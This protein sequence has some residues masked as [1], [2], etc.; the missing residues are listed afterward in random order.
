MTNGALRDIA[1]FDGDLADFLIEINAEGDLEVV[2]INGVI[3]GGVAG[4]ESAVVNIET[5]RFNDQDVDAVALFATL[6]AQIATDGDDTLTGTEDADDISGLGGND[7][8]NALGGDDDITGGP[9]DDTINAGADDDTIFWAVGDGRDLIDGGAGDD[10]FR[11]QGDGDD[12]TFFVETVGDFEQRLIDNSLP[13]PVPALSGNPL[14]VIVSRGVD[15][16]TGA[17]EIIAELDSIEDIDVNGGGGNDNFVVS[18]DFL[19]TDLD[20][21]TITIT[22]SDGDD[23]VDITGL[24][25][26]HRFVFDSNGGNDTI[27]GLLRPQDIVNLATGTELVYNG[28]NTFS[29][30]DGDSSGNGNQQIFGTDGADDLTGT[31]GADSMFGLPGADIIHGLDGNDH[32]EGNGGEDELFGGAGN[33][34]L[35]GGNR[36]DRLKGGEGDDFLW[37]G[38]SI[39]AGGGD[40]HI[41]T[42]VFDGLLGDFFFDLDFIDPDLLLVVDLVG[43]EGAD[44]G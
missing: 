18:G 8:I 16:P 39:A 28:N 37:G 15:G 21:N 1:V 24:D 34:I 9:G 2:D 29:I 11:I 41:D 30:V 20:P 4:E 23:T 19:D 43:N 31:D 12:E 5:L 17:S 14:A 44:Q 13:D 25:S 6:V 35:I 40:N 10:R 27:I 3:P 33:D 7:T 36:S 38:S 42:A 22:G 32:I 26:E